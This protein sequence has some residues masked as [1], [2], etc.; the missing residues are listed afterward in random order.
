MNGGRGRAQKKKNIRLAL[1]H[2][3]TPALNHTR[4]VSSRGDTDTVYKHT[5]TRIHTHRRC[6]PPRASPGER[7]GPARP[8]AHPPLLPPPAG[9]RRPPARLPPFR[10]PPPPRP[11]SSA[12][13]QSAW[14]TW[15]PW[16][17]SPSRTTSCA[18]SGWRSEEEEKKGGFPRLSPP[19]PHH[20]PFL[21]PLLSLH[22]DPGRRQLRQRPDRG[23]SSGR[24]HLPGLQARGRRAGRRDRGGAR[25]GWRQHGPRAG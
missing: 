15:P 21:F 18:R 17:L 1:P 4:G 14:T 8:G 25:G 7:T 13:A 2:K 19:S 12:W 23:R 6:R 22:T 11:P 9:P 3:H 5:H 10:P 20:H 24:P 16:R